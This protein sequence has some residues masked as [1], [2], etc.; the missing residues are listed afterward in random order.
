MARV[1]G[2][3]PGG[4]QLNIHPSEVTC[5]FQVLAT[6]G[7]PLLHLS[8]FGSSSRESAPKSSQSLQLDL[9]AARELIEVIRRSFPDENFG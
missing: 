4:Q 3:E 8:T 5:F 6:P 1:T 7:G 2:F 9:F